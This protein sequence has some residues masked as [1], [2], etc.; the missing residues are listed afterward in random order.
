MRPSAE[1]WERVQDLFNQAL[2][3]PPNE[4]RALLERASGGDETLRREVESLLASD[5]KAHSFIEDPAAAVPRDLLSETEENEEFAG[6]Q[7]GAYRVIREIGRGG[8]GA[9]YLAARADDEYRKQVAIKL[10]RRG[11]DT[12]DILR[13][14]RTERQI[15]A[16]LD[17]PNIARLLDGGTTEDGLPYFVMEYV[18]GEPITAYCDTHGLSIG[19]RLELFRKVC[20]AVSY[21][22]QHLVVHRDLKP[23]NILV[24][25]DG[26]P[27]LLDF[28]IA[29]LL[30]AEDE[31]FTQA[32]PGLR[33][34]T[35]DYA[36]PE[37]IKGE[38]ITTA[39]DVYSLGVLLYQL[40]TGQ[41]PYRLKTGT[42]DEISRAIAA[43]EP[44]RPSSTAAAATNT[45]KALRGDLDNIVLMALRKEPQRRYAS[46][47]QLSE[48]IRR[49]VEGRAVIAH[50]DT[51]AYRATKFIQRNKIGVAAAALVMLSLLA[52]I[53]IA[54]TQARR[55]TAHARIAE[56]QR[57]AAQRASAR[58][59]KTSRF[60][61]SFLANANP[62]WYARGQGR[63]DVTVREAIEDAAA[64][65]DTELADQPEVR[66]DLHHTIGEI[67]RV[68]SEYPRALEH[69]RR[70]LDA[71]REAYGAKH[72]K[73]AMALYYF[74]I[75]KAG[76]TDSK[77]EENELLLRDGIAMMRETDPDNL[78]L[79]Y[80]LQELAAW[81][82]A[83]ETPN[84]RERRL[85]EAEALLAEAKTLFLQHYGEDHVA[86]ITAESTLAFLAQTRGDCALAERLS[87]EVVRRFR[88]I[89]E[90]GDFHIGALSAQ[91][92]ITLA[93]GK[94][95]EAE[96][97]FAQA[98][99]MGRRQ[100]GVDD[101]RYEGLARDIDQARSSRTHDKPLDTPHR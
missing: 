36:S 85:A 18:N 2:D 44:E 24:P 58:A 7:F 72:P 52:G 23:S 25:E 56:E 43:Q 81:M 76:A 6:R 11:L 93:C 13:R 92:R 98:L 14:F 17:H 101:W 88:Q 94:T 60:M 57:D 54:F 30:T 70:S 9:V 77:T 39:S 4:R 75:T 27:K 12:D 99:D 62:Q 31:L 42:T 66:G 32:T 73:V 89:E 3:L 74:S 22:H 100:W 37:Q 64:R 35:P 5:E 19:E 86:T 15:L 20:G 28:G 95:I 61:Q 38:K 49:F 68:A 34:M 45:G 51:L 97:F 53:A 91:G 67:H 33:A 63:T 48:D 87:E 29:K 82:V 47:G 65:I 8:L 41:K 40:L 69:F 84:A 78:N 96:T 55:A 10:I 71:Y 59:E 46:V 80:M 50:K 90:G 1:A 83:N 16:Q 79:P 26:E 21:A